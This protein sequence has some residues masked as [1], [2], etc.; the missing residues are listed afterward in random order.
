MHPSGTSFDLKEL[1]EI[2][3]PDPIEKDIPSHVWEMVCNAPSLEEAPPE[4]VIALAEKRLQARA[5][6]QWGESDELRNQIASLGWM[7]QDA[8]DSYKLVKL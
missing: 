8:K 3:I 2:Q 5:N 7:V 4:D 6:K 1:G